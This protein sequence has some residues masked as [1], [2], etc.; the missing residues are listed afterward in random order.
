MTKFYA[1][2][3]TMK[4]LPLMLGIM[5]F[6]TQCSKDNETVNDGGL[7]LPKDASFTLIFFS[8]LNDPRS[9]FQTIVLDGPLEG[10]YEGWCLDSYSRI[11]SKKGY[12]GKV[13]SSLSKNIPDLFD[14]QE[15]LPLINWVI[16]FD[17][18]GKDSPGGL[19]TYTLGDVSK[20]LW[21]LLEETPNPDP[22]GGVGSFNNNRVN[23]IVEMAFIEGKEFVPLC[24]EFL[25]VILVVEGKQ[26]TMIK[27]PFPCP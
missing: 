24:G 1:M 5:L 12:V 20:A 25:A 17:F 26:T 18:V 22:A 27:Y 16:N 13:Y 7:N 8:E 2:K 15:N 3:T 6:F 23:E 21:I 19:G 10:V 11:Q 9:Y 14:Y 4:I